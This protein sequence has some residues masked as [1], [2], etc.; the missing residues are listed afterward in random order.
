M[1]LLTIPAAFSGLVPLSRPNSDLQ[2]ERLAR[3]YPRQEPSGLTV[4]SPSAPLAE[5]DAVTFEIGNG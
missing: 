2:M 3:A 4:L 5:I 1:R